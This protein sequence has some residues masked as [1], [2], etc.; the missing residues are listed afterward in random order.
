M[1]LSKEY[2]EMVTEETEKGITE[3]K[4]VAAET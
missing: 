3:V 2:R 1:T 4:E